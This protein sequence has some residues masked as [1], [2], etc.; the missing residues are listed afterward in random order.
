MSPQ[1]MINILKA[2]NASDDEEHCSEEEEDSSSSEDVDVHDK[3]KSAFV[4]TESGNPDLTGRK[5]SGTLSIDSDDSFDLEQF[6]KSYNERLAELGTDSANN[7]LDILLKRIEKESKRIK[8]TYQGKEDDEE[9]ST[10]PAEE[11]RAKLTNLNSAVNA[12]SV[13]ELSEVP[14]IASASLAVKKSKGV[15]FD[16]K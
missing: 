1:D 6:D 10:D 4:S 13:A 8:D 15:N 12:K 9:D 3:I 11:E 16:D 7:S 2:A 5:G 14:S